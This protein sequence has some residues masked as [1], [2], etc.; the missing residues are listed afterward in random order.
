MALITGVVY[1]VVRDV[2]V[3]EN[4]KG[5]FM[6]IKVTWVFGASTDE[7]INIGIKENIEQHKRKRHTEFDNLFQVRQW[8]S[9]MSQRSGG[10]LDPKKAIGVVKYALIMGDP[11]CPAEIPQWLK[12]LLAGKPPRLQTKWQQSHRKV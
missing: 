11:L 3:P 10:K 9:M 2:D 6:S 12:A 8:M 4:L 7:I 1:Y 5:A